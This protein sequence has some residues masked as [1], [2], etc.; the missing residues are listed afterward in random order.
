MKLSLITPIVLTYNEAPNI[1]TTLEALKDFP[2]IIL[3]D[4]FS[5]DETIAI[6]KLFPNTKIYQR[7]FDTHSQQ[8]NYGISKVK[9]DWILSL[10]ADYKVAPPLIEEIKA[11]PL[12]SETIAAFKIGFKY[13]VFGQA[14]RGTILPPR[15]AL[16]DR[17]KGVYIQDGHT[18]LL[19]V[20]GK[21]GKLKNTIQHDDR[22]SLSRWLWAQDR[23][24]KL[25]AQ[26]LTS[27]PNEHLSIGD[28][29][30]K[31]K[32]VAPFI[33][34]FYCLI[35]KGGI[36]DG[37]RGWYYAFQRCFAELLLSLRLIEEQ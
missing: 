8:W 26:K 4:S 36:F 15:L 31:L 13:C 35:L 1:K 5:D 10:D 12:S 29:I 9:T 11:L 18:Q 16:F 28:R 20:S 22:K 6:A 33:V 32:I 7:I 3:I 25:E 17:H 24:L 34:L 37:W 21:I 27:T 30:R 19:Q 23:Y 2:I 14:L